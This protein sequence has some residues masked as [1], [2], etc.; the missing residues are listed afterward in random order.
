MQR[1][2]EGAGQAQA[3]T[4]DA[5][6]QSV[7]PGWQARSRKFSCRHSTRKLRHPADGKGD[8][9]VEA[10]FNN[11]V[12]MFRPANIKQ[13]DAICFNN[14]LGVL[15][16][17]PELRRLCRLRRS[18]KGFVGIHDAIATFVQYRIR[19]VARVR[20]DAWRDRERRPSLERRSD[21]DEGGRSHQPDQRGVRGKD[22]QIADQAFQLRSRFSATGCTCC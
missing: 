5:R 7:D 11:D 9:R 17:D 14:T 22:F 20:P 12:E 2:R 1:F 21:D 3:A 15:F 10:V 19:S 8:G 4:P 18:G 16:D 13:F 6:D